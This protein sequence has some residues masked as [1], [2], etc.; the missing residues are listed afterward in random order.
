MKRWK[1]DDGEIAEN[2]SK[3]QA[4]ARGVVIR[5]EN[6]SEDTNKRTSCLE[7]ANVVASARPYSER[8]G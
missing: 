5:E 7:I 4:S 6:I 3:E 8:A 1:T 2:N